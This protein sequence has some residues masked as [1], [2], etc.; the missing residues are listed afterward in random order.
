MG[1]RALLVVPSLPN[2]PWQRTLVASGIPALVH[3]LA[4]LRI[5]ADPAGSSAGF[6]CRLLSE[7][8][9]KAPGR[10]QARSG[11]GKPGRGAVAVP[12]LR[13]HCC[14]GLDDSASS[15][16]NPGKPVA[17]ENHLLAL[18]AI[19]TPLSPSLRSIAGV[20]QEA[21]GNSLLWRIQV[22][23]ST[24][25]ST[26]PQLPSQDG[27]EALLI[28]PVAAIHALAGAGL[29]GIANQSPLGSGTFGADA[30]GRLAQQR[31][32]VVAACGPGETGQ[33]RTQQH[34][35]DQND[36]PNEP[37]RKA[38]VH[39]GLSPGPRSSRNRMIRNQAP[40]QPA[41]STIS[42]PLLKQL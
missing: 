31:P 23:A 22:F 36:A 42:R 26:L 7:K 9:E 4:I 25:I 40:Y 16:G 3:S 27:R 10:I 1:L 8:A 28:A 15:L 21:L 33:G 24:G 5:H 20:P 12:C 39:W 37:G 2:T 32:A 38:N 30:A 6:F 19:F 41:F 14:G 35:S 18:P 11:R 13:R 29:G 17:A 34:T